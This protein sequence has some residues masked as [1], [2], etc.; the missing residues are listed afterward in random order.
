MLS[1][2]KSDSFETFQKEL[3]KKNINESKIEKLL[4]NGIDINQ[5]DDKQRS[6]LFDMC[7]KKKLDA[8]KLLLRL[9]AN[10]N[11]EDIY[12]KTVLSDAVDREDGMMIRFL[13]DHGASVNHINSS[14]RTILQDVAIEGNA[15][16]FK[17]LMTKEPDLNI[18]DKYGNSVLFDAII[19][20]ELEIVKEI[21]NNLD[22]SDVTDS[23]GQTALFH[24]VLLEDKSIAKFLISYGLDINHLDD[25][26][27]N[28]LFNAIILGSSNI[29]LIDIFLKKGIKV[30]IKDN[31]GN[32]LL[33]ELLKIQALSIDP[34]AILEGKYKLIAK[35]RGYNKVAIIL[36]DN[37][38][39]IDRVDEDGKTILHKEIEKKNYDTIEFLIS[40]GANVNA[41]DKYGKGILF[42]V[43]LKGINNINM[44]DYLL[45]KGADIDLRDKEEKTIVDDLVEIILV[46]KNGLKPTN[47][48]YL[49]LNPNED[50]LGLLKKVLAHKPKINKQKKDGSTVLFQVLQHNNLDLIK[51]FLSSGADPDIK[52]NNNDTPFTKAIDEGLK[53]TR[54]KEREQF[55]ERLVFILKFRIDVNA[56]DSEGRTV[57]HKVVK[58]DDIEIIEKLLSK[59]SD[60]NIKD[61]QGRTALH[62][63]VWKGNYKIARLLIAAG[64]DMNAIDYAGYTTLN[65][66]AILGHTNLVVV[67]IASGVLMYNR[68]KKSKSVTNFFLERISNLDKLL[69]GNITDQKMRDSIAQVITNL[70]KEINEVV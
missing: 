4:A 57:F 42:E 3:M 41:V 68:A 69:Q 24:A 64:S 15:R 53:I 56:I 6:I 7:S 14:G 63:T 26:R 8:I 58:A 21:L 48:R 32:T 12:G 36:I 28:V 43:I 29:E 38:L 31:D 40:S 37:G 17:I 23:N 65:Y 46:Q 9:G 22:D 10:I 11:D 61:K 34:N 47:R 1:F 27:Q 16:V 49:D 25:N 54:P 70:K 19:G 66:A 52:D 35:D 59:R 62:H 60:L 5:K 13:L 20:G 51:L 33:D 39:A 44:I 45:E 2:L 55:I 67:L 18:K 50:Y 30:N